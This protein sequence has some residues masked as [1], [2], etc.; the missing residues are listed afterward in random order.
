MEAFRQAFVAWLR[1][2]PSES[3]KIISHIARTWP[4]REGREAIA[5]IKTEEAKFE[6]AD[7]KG[8][9]SVKA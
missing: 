4:L 9:T 5:F 1:T 6:H 7:W 3:W 8:Q 2:H